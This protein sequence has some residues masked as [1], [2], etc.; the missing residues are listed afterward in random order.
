M[1]MFDYFHIDNKWI[2]KEKQLPQD[3]Q[4]YQ[5]KDFE[6]YLE[7]YEVLEDGSLVRNICDEGEIRGS[8]NI[9]PYIYTGG[10]RFYNTNDEFAAWCVNGV[11]KDVVVIR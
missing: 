2:P 10:F 11:V 6:C 4:D 7:T 8:E 9:V 5:T 1:G 3:K